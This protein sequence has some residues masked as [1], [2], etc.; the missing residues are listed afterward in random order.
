MR[1][2]AAVNKLKEA[3]DKLK[4]QVIILARS[5]A[6]KGA[7]LSK[8]DRWVIPSRDRHGEQSSLYQK[9]EKILRSKLDLLIQRILKIQSYDQIASHLSL[10]ATD[11]RNPDHYFG[12]HLIR[13]GN[14]SQEESYVNIEGYIENLFLKALQRELAPTCKPAFKFI[15]KNSR[16]DTWFT[17]VIKPDLIATIH[18]ADNARRVMDIT[19]PHKPSR[20]EKLSACFGSL[21]HKNTSS[22]RVAD[23]VA[24]VPSASDGDTYDTPLLASLRSEQ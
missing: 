3:L 19:L 11:W 7:W 20:G 21:F 8:E 12:K 22:A 13:P 23:A 16:T 9:Q 4:E 18:A 24:R 10:A 15:E 1:D 6:Q 5:I 14:E 17:R 2:E